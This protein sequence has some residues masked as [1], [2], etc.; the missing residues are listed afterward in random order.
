MKTH[1]SVIGVKVH[2]Y[3][4]DLYTYTID[5]ITTVTS[6]SSLPMKVSDEPK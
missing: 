6:S 3:W 5:I 2:N 4:I 1:H